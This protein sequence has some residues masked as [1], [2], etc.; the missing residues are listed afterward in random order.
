MLSGPR[1]RKTQPR[2]HAYV[3]ASLQGGGASLK[4]FGLYDER[5]I[6]VEIREIQQAKSLELMP[7]EI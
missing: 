5:G 4:A 3:S 1:Q 7:T 6:V 2:A